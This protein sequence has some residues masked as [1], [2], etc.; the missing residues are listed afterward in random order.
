MTLA[1][2]TR[3]TG[4]FLDRIVAARRE[5]LAR[6]RVERPEAWLRERARALPAPLDFPR[7]LRRGTGATP[8]D[9][10]VRLIAEIKR[11]SPSKGLFDREIDAAELAGRYARA[12]AAAVSVLTEPDFFAGSIWD[13]EAVHREFRAEPERP[14][15]L[16]KE[17]IWDHYQ[18]L[19][20]RA[21]GADAL[22]LIV[23]LLEPPLLQ[24]LLEHSRELGMEALVEVHDE[25]EL[26]TALAA[27][28]RVL[29]VNNRDL[30][31]F[32]ED[33]ATTERLGPLVRAVDPGV[34]L[35]A[36]SAIRSAQ[37][38]RR[39]AL[40]GADAL[41]VGE[42]LVT[43]GDI[44]GRARELMMGEPQVAGRHTEPPPGTR[45]AGESS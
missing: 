40:A 11:A 9:A 16:R 28:A 24:E 20:A 25:D 32:S 27:G 42:A 22:L 1:S 43:S 7:Q 44:A 31:S 30:R 8:D 33:L 41:L 15:L 13:L 12:G 39:M 19:E 21:F 5:R 18:L 37:D 38:A 35:V 4:T 10:R 6:D 29:G 3:L 23:M 14:A 26:A 36:E 17:F 34:T 45:G 2:G